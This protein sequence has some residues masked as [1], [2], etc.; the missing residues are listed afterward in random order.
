[1]IALVVLLSAV[2]RI[3]SEI[4]L[5]D[6][7]R[8]ELPETSMPVHYDLWLQPEFDHW[9]AL[10]HGRVDIEVDVIKLTRTL[11]VHSNNIHISSTVLTDHAG[12]NIPVRRIAR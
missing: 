7:L 4:G 1:M 5:D 10:F 12:N 3:Q 2:L 6:W 11:I 9:S 8:P